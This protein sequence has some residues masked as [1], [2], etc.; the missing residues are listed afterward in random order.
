[1]TAPG[2][3]ERFLSSTRGR[4]VTMLR[5]KSRTVNELAGALGLTD[6]TV[7]AHLSTLERDGFIQQS[8][9]RAGVRRPH[10]DYILTPAAEQLFVRACDPVLE[11]LLAALPGR[12]TAAQRE[13][14]LRD[15]G[16]EMGLRY[17]G[18]SHD[19]SVGDPVQSALEGLAELGAVVSVEEAGTTSRPKRVITAARC[20]L[21]G[22]VRLHPEL[23]GA[24]ET[25]LTELAGSPVRSVCERGA[26]PRCRFLATPG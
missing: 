6:N 19:A 5:D 25:Y 1:M 10:R 18:N 24:I 26:E 2:W 13:G 17:R 4:I 22:M 20:P 11:G 12:V 8:G 3:G 7:R 23:C 14:L 16:R 21:A 15:A 9:M